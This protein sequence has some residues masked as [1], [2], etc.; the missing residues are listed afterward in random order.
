[1]V[2]TDH[3]PLFDALCGRDR[4][5]PLVSV[6]TPNLNQGRFIEETI[7]SI[8]RQDYPQI[9]HIIID[10]GSTDESGQILCRCQ[11]AFS[12][13]W[14]SE[15]DNGQAAAINRGF[16]L[17]RGEIIGWLNSDDAYFDTRA[18]RAAV[19]AL[20]EDPKID[21]VYGDIVFIAENGRILRVQCAPRYRT[22]RLRRGCFIHQPAVFFKRR[23]IDKYRLDESLIYTM[24]YEFWLRSSAEFSFKHLPRILA[25]DRHYPDR[26]MVAGWD[27]L[28]REKAQVQ[29]RY[30]SHSRRWLALRRAADRALSG[31]PRRAKGLLRFLA[32]RKKNDFAFGAAL[33][34]IRQ[35][36]VNQLFRGS[37]LR[38]LS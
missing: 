38:L 25:A 8:Q 29:A 10:G 14:L 5:C 16:A 21:I 28:L 36:I 32:L 30:S 24:D 22:S 9:E 23:V 13:R 31:M 17:A 12:I 2:R 4:N 3:Q 15:P 7:L 27:H 33:P 1:M 6:V 19:A 34:S 26:K 37:F 11:K 18:V 20:A 35:M